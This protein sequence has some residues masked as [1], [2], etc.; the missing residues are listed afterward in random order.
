MKFDRYTYCLDFI[1]GNFN[2]THRCLYRYLNSATPA[3]Y[4]AG[5]LFWLLDSNMLIELKKILCS[6]TIIVF[7]LIINRV[8][9]TINPGFWGNFDQR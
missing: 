6:V 7:I 9:I 1:N 5:G 2:P 3:N 4:R 8:V